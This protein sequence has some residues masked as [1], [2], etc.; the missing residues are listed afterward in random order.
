VTPEG[1]ETLM[2]NAEKEQRAESI[3][4]LRQN[5]RDYKQVFGSAAGKR[6]L[7]DIMTKSGILFEDDSADPN[8]NLIRKG[9][10]RIG[11]SILSLICTDREHQ[12]QKLQEQLN[13]KL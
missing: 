5:Q 10:R 3:K 6:V 9:E 8:S 1:S 12:L 2:T 11:R 13:R 7:S 4:G